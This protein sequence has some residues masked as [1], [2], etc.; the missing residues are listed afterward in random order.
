MTGLGAI[1]LAGGRGSRVG[2]AVKPL[3]DVGGATLLATAVAAARD[4][5]ARPITVAGPILDPGLGVEW[6]REDPPYGG[7]AAAVVA[8]LS[9]WPVPSEPEWALLLACDLPGARAAVHRLVHDLPLLPA[10]TDG[11]CLG[12]PASRPQ[13]LTGVYRTTTL[14][15]AASALPDHGTGASMRDLLAD[16]AIAVVAAPAPLTVD[17]DTWEDLEEARARAAD[18]ESP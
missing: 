5:A 13:W 1:L 2:G 6:V 14:R 3:L 12:D 15:D 16:L 4:A 8:A 11:L 17:I 10:D 9:S 18:E 7:P